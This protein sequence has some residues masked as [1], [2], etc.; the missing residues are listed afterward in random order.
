[1]RGEPSANF[2]FDA[3]IERTLC[4]KLRKTRLQKLAEHEEN[5]SNHSDTELEKEE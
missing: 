2:A 1:M 4:A 5:N 3:K